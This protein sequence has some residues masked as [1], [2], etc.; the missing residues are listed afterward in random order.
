MQIDLPEELAK[1]LQSAV[2][3]GLYPSIEAAIDHAITL[4]LPTDDDDLAW[5]KPL[6]DEAREAIAKGDYLTLE[7][8]RRGVKQ[9]LDDLND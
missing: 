2:A 4:I 6:V 5:A 9:L 8:Y 3:A 1:T 7:Q